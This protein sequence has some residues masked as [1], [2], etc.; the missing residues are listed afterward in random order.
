MYSHYT[1]SL[2]NWAFCDALYRYDGGGCILYRYGGD[3]RKCDSAQCGSDF[4]YR[5]DGG[6]KLQ[7]RNERNFRIFYRAYCTV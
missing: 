7:Y 2:K 4:L 3:H 5:Y 1:P 6:R